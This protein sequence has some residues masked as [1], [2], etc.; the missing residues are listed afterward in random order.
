MLPVA[1]VMN[2]FYTGLGIARSLGARGVPVIGLSSKRHIFGNATRYAKTMIC[3]DS[4]SEP[5]ALLAFLL[6]L[7]REIG[8]RGVLFPTRDDDL[9]FLDRFR[10]ALDPYFSIVIPSREA[11]QVCL[12]K[13]ETFECAERSQVPA[14]KAWIVEG[15]DDLERLHPVITYPC[16]LK[17][18]AAHH[19][20]QGDNWALVGC[21]KAVG[22]YGAPELEAE[23][24]TIA[25]ADKRALVQEMVTGT[26]DCLLIVACYLDRESR[27][28]AGFN[29]QK[30][31]QVPE[32]FGTGC[33][34]QSVERPELFEPTMRLL[35]TMRFTGIAEVEYKW[36]AAAAAYKLIE[37][38]PRPWDQHRLGQAAGID[39][40]YIAYCE[41]AG[42]P[43]PLP[44]KATTGH[45][46]IA[47][48]TFIYTAARLV[49]RE[50]SK[51]RR[52]FH[53]ARGKRIYAIWSARDPLPSI[54][55]MS[56]FISE[57]TGAG[58]RALWSALR[59][60]LLRSAALPKKEI[61][62]ES[63]VQKPES[64]R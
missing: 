4:R 27:W 19:W 48:D 21:R 22:I 37:V 17:P 24:K 25:R 6:R 2:V 13:W 38:N 59:N 43:I 61:V 20:R 52:L 8:R 1:I 15:F 40:M 26:D 33:I 46:W 49:L 62:N 60:G 41:H 57:L 10:D 39:L 14:P 35:R 18:L 32:G 58:L 16:V 31:L 34:V 5:E 64:V 63:P 45:K 53:L 12:N 44:A 50:P 11:L 9:V 7:G 29:T 28:V 30:V 36:D 3:P 42:L 23:Y 54:V 47:E 51:L 55:W 56:T